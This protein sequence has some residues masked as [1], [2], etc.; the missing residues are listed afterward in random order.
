VMD[1]L[2]EAKEK[3]IINATVPP[4]IRSTR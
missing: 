3:G 1:V 4:S 2:S